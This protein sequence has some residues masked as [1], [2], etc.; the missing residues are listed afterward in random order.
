MLLSDVYTERRTATIRIISPHMRSAV[1]ESSSRSRLSPAKVD[2]KIGPLLKEAR[3]AQSF[4]RR[5]R[6]GLDGMAWLA[7]KL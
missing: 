2:P 5:R 1:D 4:T 6:Q 7:N 3:A